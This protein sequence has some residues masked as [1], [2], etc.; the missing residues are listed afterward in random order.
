MCRP[1]W[2]Q[3]SRP[4]QAQVYAALDAE[5][6]LGDGYL[7]AV[8]KAVNEVLER[9]HQPTG[10]AHP[11]RSPEPPG[12]MDPNTGRMPSDDFTDGW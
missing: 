11:R 8:E 2:W 7:D 5:G 9:R 4:T 10:W 12:G 6:P 3:V 1:H